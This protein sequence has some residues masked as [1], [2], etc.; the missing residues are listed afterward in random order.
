MLD[1]QLTKARKIPIFLRFHSNM[2]RNKR[3]RKTMTTLMARLLGSFE[4]LA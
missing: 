4:G 1:G 3:V 2:K